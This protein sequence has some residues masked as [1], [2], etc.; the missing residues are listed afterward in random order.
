MSKKF[1]MLKNQLK[2]IILDN[3]E[4]IKKTETKDRS[5]RLDANGNYAITGIRRCGKS[6]L[7]IN[8]LQKLPEG[9]FIYLNFEDE[10]FI[11]FGTSDFELIMECSKELFDQKPVFYFD[12]IQN[13]KGWEKFVRRLADSNYRVLITGS[14]AT[15]LSRE[16][17]SVLGGRFIGKEILPLSFQEY[18]SFRNIIP[19]KNYA[20][21]KERFIIK[22]HFNDF[23][24]FGGFPELIKFENS[25]EYLS[26][27]FMKVFYG[28]LI[29]RNG[30]K[31][32]HVLK[33]LI[34]KLAE[35]VNNETSINRFKNLIQ[36]TGL[37]VGNNTIFDYLNYLY[38]SCLIFGVENYASSFSE[39]ESKKKYYFVD[40]G[41]LN[42]FL[43]NQDTKLLEN[44]VF[45]ELHRRYPGQVF[46]FKRKLESD[47][48]IPDL[49]MIIQVSYSVAE[50]ETRER[51][52][53]ALIICMKELKLEQ[54]II[55]S[56]D[57]ES[58]IEFQGY[59]IQVIP[60]W[61]W[62]LTGME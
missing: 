21:T 24:Y 22:E 44:I 1:K 2:K 17:A 36:S 57:E 33:L 19:Q 61:K 32:D 27:I 30:I 7:L 56:Y 43:I 11:E 13:I 20:F 60:A 49:K 45:I 59:K 15:M 9:P 29:T 28:D 53:K 34:K 38:D 51:E 62:L 50:I 5:A 14:N 4:F 39:K 46:Y 37:K 55:I 10:R 42:L 3:I 6:Y 54:G 35:S 16:L 48:Y 8:E 52:C 31:N 41:I 12:E 40:Q 23:F 26:N 58:E 25:R 47:F 18:L